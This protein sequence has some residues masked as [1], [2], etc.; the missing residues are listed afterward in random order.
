M[1]YFSCRIQNV[2]LSSCLMWR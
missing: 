2:Y 1:N